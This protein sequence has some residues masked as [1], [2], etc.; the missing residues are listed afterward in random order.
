MS[1]PDGVMG[2]NLQKNC[3]GLLCLIVDERYMVGSN[4]LG[5]M[6]YMIRHGMKNASEPW[7]GIPAI[8]SLVMTVSFLQYVTG[9]CMCPTKNLQ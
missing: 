2:V 7:G 9:Q 1:P 4:T 3:E 8:F 5:W 6:E